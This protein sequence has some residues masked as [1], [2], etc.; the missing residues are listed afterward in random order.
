MVEVLRPI[1]P[2]AWVPMSIIFWPTQEMSIGFVILLGAF[3]T[4]TL[5]TLYGARDIDPCFVQSALSM[6]T[7]S[8]TIFARIVLP[9]TLPNI[10]TG[11]TIGMGI[12]W[13][14]VVAAEMISGSGGGQTGGGLGHL[15]WDA[16]IA[17]NLAQ[18]LVGMISIGLAGYASSALIR[19][20]GV[21]AT[22]WVRR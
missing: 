7:P 16:Y 10:V 4:I 20:A 17:G 9:A 6:G 2:I 22:P 15:I 14:V 13:E 18:I 5:S 21:L 12:T 1:P 3:Y 11:A 19:G 8:R